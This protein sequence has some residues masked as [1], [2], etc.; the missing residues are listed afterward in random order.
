M[1]WCDLNA[2]VG[3]EMN[4]AGGSG[5]PPDG[6]EKGKPRRIANV[7]IFGNGWQV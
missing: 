1:D 5:S 2:H 3:H 4:E 6:R 7:D